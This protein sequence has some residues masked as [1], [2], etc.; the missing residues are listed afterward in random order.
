MNKKA[1]FLTWTGYS[2][3]ELIYA[4]YRLKEDDFDIK[5]LSNV[6]SAKDN[7]KPLKG[8]NGCS[9]HSDESVK[10]VYEYH[11]CG[12]LV[13]PG[14]VKGMEKLRQEKQVIDFITEW[15]KQGKTIASICHGSQ[16][17]ISAKILKGRRCSG[18]YSI[19]D[20]ITNAGGVYV[21]EPVVVDGNLITTAHYKD[22]G[23]WMRAA[24]DV[25]YCKSIYN[26]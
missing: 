5:I 21:D 23:K 20:D 24:L 7:P 2:D 15:D 13:L 6:V 19:A 4:Y 22:Q 3:E 9:F 26:T 10:N 8:V 12:F 25:Y 17:L 11:D 16:L 1:L 18:Y 14:G